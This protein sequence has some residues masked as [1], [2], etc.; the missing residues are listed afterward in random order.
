MMKFLIDAIV[1]FTGITGIGCIFLVIVA[2][3]NGWK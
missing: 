1:V 3:L 2:W